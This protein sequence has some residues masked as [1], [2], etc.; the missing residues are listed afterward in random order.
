MGSQANN[1]LSVNIVSS[2]TVF[3]LGLCITF[4]LTPYIVDRLGAAAYGFVGLSNNI[5]GYTSLLTV[6][7]NSMAGRFVTLKYHKGE[8]E[9]AN[10]Y[11]SS[12]LMANVALASFFLLCFITIALFLPHFIDIPPELESDVRALFMLLGISSCIGLLTG[13]V[14]VS[15]FITNRLDLSNIRYLIGTILRTG[16]L[17]VAFGLF[18]PKLWYIGLAALILSLYIIVTNIILMHRLT[19]DINIHYKKL[20]FRKI[21]EVT[22]AGAWNIITRLSGMLS[23]GFDL[24]FAN[25]FVSATAMGLLSITQTIPFLLLSLFSTVSS[26]FNPELTRLYA[27]NDIT[28]M[29]SELIKSVKLCGFL[30]C[31]PLVAVFVFSDSFYQLWLPDQDSELLY[32][33]TMVAMIEMVIATPL[34][35]LWSIFTITNNVKRSSLNLLANSVLSFSAILIVVVFVKSDIIKLFVLASS[36][37]IFSLFRNTTFLPISGA[38]CLGLPRTSFFGI[39]IKNVFNVVIVGMAAYMIKHTIFTQVTWLNLIGQLTITLVVGLSIA[40]FTI[41]N[42]NERIFLFDKIR[43]SIIK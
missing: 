37:S 41:L 27:V 24:L 30:S 35:P 38:K 40:S 25:I 8:I 36:R 43:T 26:N 9:E 10:S 21:K 34:E 15:T 11:I 14:G 12:I 32:F 39:I 19:P 22:T 1:R 6:A 42:R 7:L 28:S 29:R 33:L 5:I 20:D 18:S 2:I 31:V 23:R 4:F 13:I 3:V 17:L 16:T